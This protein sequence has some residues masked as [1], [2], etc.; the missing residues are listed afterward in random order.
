MYNKNEILNLINENQKQIR[1]LGV[2][3]LGIFGSYARNEQ[4]ETSDIDFLVEFYND[5]KNFDNFM[6]LFNLL[7][8]IFKIKIE[9]VTP[10]SLTDF[11]KDKILKGTQNVL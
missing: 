3:R 8:E 1:L 7:D 10:E 6:D 5:K 2:E 11:M 4:K 9:L